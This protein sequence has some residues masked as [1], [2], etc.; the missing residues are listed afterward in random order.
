MCKICIARHLVVDI[1]PWCNANFVPFPSRTLVARRMGNGSILL[2]TCYTYKCTWLAH[3]TFCFHLTNFKLFTDCP[4]RWPYCLTIIG[5]NFV[6][7]DLLHQT[8]VSYNGPWFAFPLSTFDDITV[9]SSCFRGNPIFFDNSLFLKK[10][11]HPSHSN[12]ASS[13]SMI[14]SKKITLAFEDNCFCFQVTGFFYQ[15]KWIFVKN[16]YKQRP[17]FQKKKKTLVRQYSHLKIWQ[18]HLVWLTENYLQNYLKKE[19]RPVA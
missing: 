11:N 14:I 4:L 9:T 12:F 6:S 15:K 2:H 8:L 19:Q 13:I 18:N 3:S 10:W 7:N 16:V 17:L 1:F 5:F